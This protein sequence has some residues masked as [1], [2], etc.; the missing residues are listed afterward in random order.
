[1]D[2]LDQDGGDGI[3][4]PPHMNTIQSCLVNT[5]NLFQHLPLLST[6]FRI[7]PMKMQKSYNIP[8]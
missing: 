4:L 5:N 1:M 3:V 8:F 2:E 7:I 6:L